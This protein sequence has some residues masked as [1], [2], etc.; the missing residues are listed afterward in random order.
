MFKANIYICRFRSQADLKQSER[1]RQQR[2]ESAKN[3]LA[4]SGGE[5]KFAV[6]G[7][8]YGNGVDSTKEDLAGL[9]KN[10]PLCR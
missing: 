5:R 4:S 3:D 6:P 9:G 7:T 2:A 8:Q 1:Q 10:S